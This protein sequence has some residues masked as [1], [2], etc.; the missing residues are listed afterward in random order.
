MSFSLRQKVC[1]ACSSSK[2]RCDRQLPECQRCLD[3][4]VDCVYPQPKRRRRD[5]ITVDAQAEQI[6]SLQIFA[7]DNILENSF[8]FE[9][10]TEMGAVDLDTDLSDMLHPHLPTPSAS[11]TGPSAHA[12]AFESSGTAL[13][14][15]LWFLQDETWAIQ[16][17]QKDADCVV[18]I[19]FELKTFVRAV[20]DML[21]LW[22]KNG[23][24]SFI[25]RRL[26]EKGMPAPIQ[27]AFTTLAAYL[28]R[29][30]A[31]EEVILQIAE[32]RATALVH[33]DLPIDRG[34]Q[35]ILDHLARVQALFVY[36]FIRL[37]DG[38]LRVRT[39]AEK[40]L[41]V[42]RQWVVR[43]WETAKDYQGAEISLDH[44]HIQQTS[45]RF[46]RDY[47]ACSELWKLWILTES[48]RRTHIVVESTIN[49]YEALTKG[50]AECAGAAM[51]TARRGLWEAE[52]ANKWFEMTCAKSPLLV[53]SLQPAP[54]ISQYE[55]DDFDDFT[56]TIWAVIVGTDRI[57]H[58]VDRSS[59]KYTA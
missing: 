1:I 42:L 50:W 7:N 55:A 37:F 46:E 22:V 15:Q 2:R 20:G 25:H 31:V 54:L 36:E 59:K 14:S 16:R 47:D 30:S 29:T 12:L 26:Y 49:V 52:Y 8:D 51:M 58:W 13:Q 19:E 56:K 4:D 21:Q 48:V 43:M 33:R 27:D 5:R 32:D 11:V 17:V 9:S 24:N 44:N 45:S 53:P 3:R 35:A 38:S 39:S 41:P 23:Y 6:P 34:A 57:Q 18:D 40:Q 10:W 28:G